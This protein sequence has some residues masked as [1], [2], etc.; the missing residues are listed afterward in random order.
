[1]AE[2]SR[3][4]YLVLAQRRVG[5]IGTVWQP[6]DEF[7]AHSDTS[8][9]R[10]A[11]EKHGLGVYVAVPVRSWRPRTVAAETVEKITVSAAPSAVG[12]AKQDPKEEPVGATV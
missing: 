12:P 11:A 9:V 1:M 4:T 10:Q 2:S 7:E 6:V 8:A 3:T 5:D